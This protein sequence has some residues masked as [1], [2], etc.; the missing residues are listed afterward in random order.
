M[1]IDQ[2]FSKCYYTIARDGTIIGR[3][4]IRTGLTASKKQLKSVVYFDTVEDQV[5]YIAKQL[6]TLSKEYNVTYVGYETLSFG[7][8]GNATRNLAQLLGGILTLLLDSG[9]GSKSLLGFSPSTVKARARKLLPTE[10]QTVEG[11]KVKMTKALVTR[12]VMNLEGEEY[13]SGLTYSGE[14]AGKDDCADSR[15]ILLLTEELY[16]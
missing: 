16:K 4:L 11:K 2:S 1:A 8:I 5:Y 13:F 6:C 14:K 7:S 15:V 12:A 10:E 3:G 9:L